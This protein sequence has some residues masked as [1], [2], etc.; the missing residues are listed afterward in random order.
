MGSFS[1][2]LTILRTSDETSTLEI[3]TDS[4]P[5]HKVYRRD[6]FKL[7]ADTH[8]GKIIVNT[9]AA[10]MFIF[11]TGCGVLELMQNYSTR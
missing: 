2:A 11:A 1:T 7:S 6:C 4:K 5:E 9:L 3:A 10:K 8:L